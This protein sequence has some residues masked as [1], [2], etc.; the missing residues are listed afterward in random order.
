MN[1]I[2]EV[3]EICRSKFDKIDTIDLG[4]NKINT[5]PVAM[6]HFMKSLCQVNLI[7][8]DIQKL[9][10]IIGTHKSLKNIS[11][12]GNPLKS[13]RRPIV[14]GGSGR[15]M[16]YLHDK[17]NDQVDGVVEQWALDQD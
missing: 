3:N 13:I 17:F 10:N 12:D 9:P 14:D 16:K 1:K 8:N 4:T 15:L 6:F 2:T 5:I 11:V 7:N